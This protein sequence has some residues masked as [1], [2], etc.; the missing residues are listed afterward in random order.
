LNHALTALCFIADERVFDRELYP[1]YVNYIEIN[2]SIPPE[3]CIKL[4]MTPQEELEK[5]P[6]YKEWV[7][8]L[9]GVKNVFLR[10]LIKN[11]KL[12]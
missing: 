8:L 2:Y 9:G 3:E 10:D 4:R 6:Y 12:A 5:S 7:R 1:D 11:K